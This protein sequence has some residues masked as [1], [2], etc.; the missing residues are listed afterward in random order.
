MQISCKK[1]G[2]LYCPVCKKKCPKCGVVDVSDDKT[3]HIREQM[4]R[5]ME[6]TKPKKLIEQ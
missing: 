6:K 4:S 2:E 1:C 3:M 5:H